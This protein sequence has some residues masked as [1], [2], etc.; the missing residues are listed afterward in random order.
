MC[1]VHGLHN[2]SNCD[3]VISLK[4]QYKQGDKSGRV[5]IL[6]GNNIGHYERRVH[7]NLCLILNGDRDTPF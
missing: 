4:G 6:V 7:V 3:Y 1:P 2:L 5:S